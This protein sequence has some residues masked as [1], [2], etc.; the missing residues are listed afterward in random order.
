MVR[1][2]EAMRDE[3]HLRTAQSLSRLMIAYG[4]KVPANTSII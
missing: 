1:C 4:T 2:A 3:E